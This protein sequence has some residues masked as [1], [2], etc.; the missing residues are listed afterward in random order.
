M[1]TT[2]TTE[3]VTTTTTTE[4]VTTTTTTEDVTTTTTTEDVT[5]TT[6]TEDVTTTT[7]TEDVTTTTTTEDVTTTTTTENITTTTTYSLPPSYQYFKST[8][9]AEINNNVCE[10][11]GYEVT[12]PFWVDET[13]YSIPNLLGKPIFRNAELTNPVMDGFYVVNG[14]IINSTDMSPVRWIQVIG[15]AV[16]DV[17]VTDCGDETQN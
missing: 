7:T 17:G 3:D 2:T 9:L 10:Q 5:T 1:T 15:G 11:P 12:S 14:E 16:S 6:T 8:V 13:G 4:D